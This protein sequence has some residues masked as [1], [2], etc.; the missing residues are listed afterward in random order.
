[1]RDEA[2]LSAADIALLGLL[3]EGPK[4]PWEISKEVTYRE[5]RTWTELSQSTIYKQLH[6]LQERGLVSS[7]GEA[8]QGRARRVYAITEEGRQAVAAGVI[9]LLAHPDYPR[10]RID[11]ATY[12][13]D[14][15]DRDDTVQALHRYATALAERASG[16][17]ALEEFLR[18]SG[19]PPHRWALARRAVHLIEGELRWIGEFIDE[20]Q[21]TH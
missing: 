17:R 18:A 12:N 4:H 19:C 5:M 9:D 21:T 13:I 14:L 3:A 15:A 11:I 7:T 10:W 20:L 8:V 2:P 6:S 16:W 1:M